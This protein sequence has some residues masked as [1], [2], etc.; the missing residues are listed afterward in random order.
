MY[1]SSFTQHTRSGDRLVWVYEADM[2]IRWTNADND[3][4]SAVAVA[5]KHFFFVP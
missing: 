4:G 5:R 1:Y 3:N 2:T